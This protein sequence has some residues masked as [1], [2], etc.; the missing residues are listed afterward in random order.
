MPADRVHLVRH[1]EVF[2]PEGVL[3]GRLP[4]FGLSDLG[5]RMAAAAADDL[6][7]R[8]RPV[9]GLFSSPLQRARESAQPISEAFG[10]EP[11]I[12]E[13]IIE[14]TNAF[15]GTRM[16]GPGGSLRRPAN[17][18]YLVNPWKPSW[19]EA[20]SSVTARMLAAMNDARHSVESGDV[21][22]VSH[23][24]PIWV[25]HLV[26]TGKRP[27]HDPRKRRCALSS[28]TSFEWHDGRFVELGYTDPGA[29]IA[30]DATDVGAV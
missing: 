12:D 16:R 28:I 23:Q 4:H 18:R 13:R 20:F 27:A 22:M 11:Q 14:P 17:W 26:I 6:V 3:Y 9:T 25:T 29:P 1:G 30:S 19:G 2:N 8:G 10:L 21:A 15:E 5:K 7:S 24:L